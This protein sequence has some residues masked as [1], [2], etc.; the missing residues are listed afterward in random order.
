MTALAPRQVWWA[1][2]DPIQGHEQADGRPVL[3]VSSRFH[4][5]L[6]RQTL[7][8]VLPMTTRERS[9]FLHRVPVAVPGQPTSYL[10]TEQLR[11]LTADRLAGR[12]PMWELPIDEIA[13]VR[14]VLHRMIDL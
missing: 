5:Q 9:G 6:T 14:R 8:S 3:I 13:E 10:L 7:L 2:L 4:L 11:T 12:T 1:D